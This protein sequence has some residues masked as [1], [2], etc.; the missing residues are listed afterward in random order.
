MQRKVVVLRH[1]LG[2][3]VRET[4]REP[5]DNR[6][7]RRAYFFVTASARRGENAMDLK[8][9]FDRALDGGPAHRPI[10]DRLAVG[11]RAA[12]RRRTAMGASVLATVLVGGV[13]WAVAPGPGG[14]KDGS[15]ATSP[16]I[17]PAPTTPAEAT[18][19]PDRFRMFGYYDVDS[20]ELETA[21]GLRIEREIDSPVALEGVVSSAAIATFKGKRWWLYA[22]VLLGQESRS[23]EVLA[24]ADRPFEQWVLEQAVLHT[25]EL[26]SKSVLDPG[27]V[28][29][30][31]R[32][33]LTAHQGATIVEQTSPARVD[34]APADVPSA[35]ATIEV[36]GALICVV[37]RILPDENP[38]FLYLPET[39]NQ[40]CGDAVP[41]V[42]Y[43][44]HPDSEAP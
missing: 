25:N 27:W 37:A 11:R 41:G 18:T 28:T 6:S 21:P 44:G 4:A 39:E 29:L 15:V 3:D 33:S 10:E 8:E 23:N 32:G 1:W 2:L 7:A 9:S 36:D 31:A 42:D 35:A 38:D 19:P 43:P 16:T 40:G 17:N 20:A 26:V 22:A 13:G 14:A 24:L 12:R 30:D 5:A 34:Q